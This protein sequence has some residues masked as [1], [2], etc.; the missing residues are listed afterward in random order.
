MAFANPQGG[1][2][3]F[4]DA[5]RTLL[6]YAGDELYGLSIQELTHPEDR[7]ESAA[8]LER[9]WKGEVPFLDFEKR[10]RRKDG[11]FIWVRTTTALVRDGNTRRLLGR[12]PA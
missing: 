3:R 11:T 12:V 5:F 8:N 1:F 9:L 7:A 10:Y 4:N 6:G 2:L